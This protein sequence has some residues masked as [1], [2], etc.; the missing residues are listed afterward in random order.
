MYSNEVE[1]T[2]WDICDD[3]KLKKSFGLHGLQTEERWTKSF[4]HI[5]AKTT[6]GQ[7]PFVQNY[8]RIE[9]SSTSCYWIQINSSFQEPTERLVWSAAQ[10]RPFAWYSIEEDCEVKSLKLIQK[11]FSVVRV[12]PNSAGIDFIR[13]NLTSTDVR[14][15]RLMPSKPDAGPTLKQHCFN[16][17]CVLGVYPTKKVPSNFFLNLDRLLQYYIY[18]VFNAF[19]PKVIQI[20]RNT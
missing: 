6:L 11:Y 2:N 13:Q 10:H 18:I 14:F 9:S 16:V 5:S 17:L 12:N 4:E 20:I 15:W 8:T 19:I 3:F 7:I 1:R